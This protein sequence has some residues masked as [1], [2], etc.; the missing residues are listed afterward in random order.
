MTIIKITFNLL[1]F[2]LRLHWRKFLFYSEK[3]KC[4]I[5]IIITKYCGTQEIVAYHYVDIVIPTFHNAWNNGSL[6]SCVLY[7]FRSN[8][9]SPVIPHCA[10]YYLHPSSTECIMHWVASVM[11][12]DH[13]LAFL[14]VKR[15]AHF[16]FRHVDRLQPV[17]GCNPMH[18]VSR[19][20]H[21]VS[22]SWPELWV[23][24]LDTPDFGKFFRAN[25]RPA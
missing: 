15:I 14:S 9:F 17:T 12:R 11:H 7:F 20:T 22:R 25:T 13:D 10:Y 1:I 18:C 19:G 5:Y 6:Q 24:L 16:L 21:I 23:Q 4:W 2:S 8:L 3:R